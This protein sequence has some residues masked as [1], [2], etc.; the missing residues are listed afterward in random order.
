MLFSDLVREG[1]RTLGERPA[2]TLLTALG[3]VLGVAT[4]VG[5]LGLSETANHQVSLRFDE[6]LSSRVVVEP[7]SPADPGPV[8]RADLGPVAEVNGVTGVAR[9][10]TLGQRLAGSHPV[11]GREISVT[12]V[13]V[14]GGFEQPLEIEVVAGTLWDDPTIESVGAAVALMGETVALEMNTGPFDGPFQIWVDGSPVTVVGVF[15]AGAVE[16][17]A[18]G[19]LLVPE[20]TPHPEIWG[21]A[22]NSWMVVRVVR[23]AGTGVADVLPFVLDAESPHS[24][25]ALAPPEPEML[26]ANIEGDTQ[27]AFLMA[28]GIALL[29]G[30]VAITS[31]TLTSVVE[32]TEQFGIR[33]AFGARRG[34]IARLVVFETSLLG[35]AGGVVGC[36]LG[37][38]MILGFSV[39]LGWT[40]VFDPKLIPLAILIGVLLGALAGLAPAIRAATVEPVAALRRV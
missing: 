30:A 14:S 5:I 35:A 25:V 12:P 20:S 1:L 7:A 32:R 9:L 34:D 19:W 37:L 22:R 13:A 40:P 11:T 31:A 2:R 39:G 23:G 15:R 16:G 8:V 18:N 21:D 4:V 10:T 29:A 38:V 3:S 27:V 26:R 6:I 33:R 36:F 24:F 28:G 17:R